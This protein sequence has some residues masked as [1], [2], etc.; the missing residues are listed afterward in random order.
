MRV[1][2][3]FDLAGGRLPMVPKVVQQLIASFQ[4]DSITMDEVA[5]K[6]GHDQVLTAR[7]LR[8]ANSAHFGSAGKVGTLHDAVVLLGFDKLRVLVITS[9]LAGG[10]T[11]IPGFDMNAFWQR[12]FEIANTARM[13]GRLARLDAELAYTCGLLANI[14]ELVLHVAV[15]DKATQIDRAV[16]GG[17]ARPA[18]ERMLLGVDLTEVGAELARRWNFPDAIQGAIRHQHDPAAAGSPYA[19]VLG[20]SLFLVA[21]FNQD[22]SEEEMLGRL[23]GDGLARLGIVPDDLRQAI[24]ALHETSITTDALI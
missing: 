6:V 8:L 1:A 5:D 22:M 12:C 21:G 7:V 3:V 14:G 16:A 20:L 9:G 23:P 24:G 10:A 15:P 13:L 2:D 11:S 17:A 19:V 18:T 4:D